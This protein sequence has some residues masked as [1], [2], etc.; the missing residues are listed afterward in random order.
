MGWEFNMGFQSYTPTYK[1]HRENFTR[2]FSP[3]ASE[4]YQHLQTVSLPHTLTIPADHIVQRE[5]ILCLRKLLENPEKFDEHLRKF[6]LSVADHRYCL[7]GRLCSTIGAVVMMIGASSGAYADLT[8]ICLT[9]LYLQL[10]G[11]RPRRTTSSFGSP[12]RRNSLWS[13]LHVLAPTWLT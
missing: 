13:P 10:S 4:N 2:G 8:F 7:P 9:L 3:K 1:K 5:I 6:V 12:R 11:M